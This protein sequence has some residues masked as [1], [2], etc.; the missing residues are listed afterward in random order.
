MY[1]SSDVTDDVT[2]HHVSGGS[3]RSEHS[4][5]VGGALA[6]WVSHV[7]MPDGTAAIG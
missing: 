4:L 7:P 1:G 5:V 2:S 3:G 6:L